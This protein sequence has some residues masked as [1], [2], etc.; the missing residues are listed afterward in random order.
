MAT[1]K[2]KEFSLLKATEKLKIDMSQEMKT[3]GY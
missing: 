2:L 3:N 1:I